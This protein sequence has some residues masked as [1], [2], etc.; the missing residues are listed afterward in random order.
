MFRS[1]IFQSI[2]I[3][4]FGLG[5][6]FGQNTNHNKFKQ[7]KE[8]LPTPNSYRTAS[9]APGHDYWQNRAD[10]DMDIRLDDEN[11]K[12]YGS[13]TITYHNKSKD[14]L[15]YLWLQLDQNRMKRNSFAKESGGA[16]RKKI[17][18]RYT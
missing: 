8:E 14:E 16:P 10:Y 11:Q 4:F 5:L 17:T 2:A 9:G 7:L 12:L 3:T 15:R 13:E 6:L 18:Y 1:I